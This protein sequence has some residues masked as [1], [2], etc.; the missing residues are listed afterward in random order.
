M[1]KWIISILVVILLGG[2]SLPNIKKDNEVIQETADQEEESIIPY[3]QISDSY[4]PTVLEYKESKT[5]GMVVSNLHSKYDVAEFEK[6]LMRVATNN[7][8]TDKYYFQEGQILSSE[9]VNSWLNRKYTEEQLKEREMTA[10]QNLGLNPVNDGSGSVEEQNTKN[11]IYLAHVLEH[12]YL[13]KED[14]KLRLG[15]I[16]IGLALN[17]VHYYQK[18]KYGDTFEVAIAHKELAE[19]GKKMAVEI[20]ERLRS[21][22]EVG[23][24]IPITI[25]LFEQRSKNAVTPGNFFAYAHGSKK[26]SSLGDWKSVNEKTIL[27]P[28]SEAEK[29][30]KKESDPFLAFK[31]EIEKY[32]SN[33]IG[34]IGRGFYVD[35]QLH[36]LSIEIPLQ[37]YGEAELIG[38]TQWAASL[39]MEYFPQY[40]NVEVDIHSME[41][42]EA[43]I[44]K[45]AGDKEPF[46]HIY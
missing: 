29:D 27:F 12:D 44:I 7:F 42:A 23:D 45:N 35:D 34:V 22:E 46:V 9:V 40:F 8:S 11:P 5:R 2:C 28:S 26:G 17:S 36:K 16:V 21:M 1:K 31:D 20:Y 4:Y 38:F 39:V 41:G 30:F 18:E 13:V 37:M 14:K 3:I 32:F 24:D 33:Y 10:E 19:Q 6:G 43:L 15:G 25:A